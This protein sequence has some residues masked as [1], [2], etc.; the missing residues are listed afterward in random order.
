MNTQTEDFTAHLGP[1]EYKR[2][3][4]TDADMTAE[5]EY[6]HPK[7]RKNHAINRNNNKH[8]G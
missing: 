4:R 2:P 8:R 6:Y 5:Y 1:D 3:K 7:E